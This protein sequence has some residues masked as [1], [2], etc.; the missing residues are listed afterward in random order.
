MGV[1]HD[2]THPSG[3]RFRP[4]INTDHEWLY[5]L[6]E[7]AHRELVER[8]YGPWEEDQQWDFFRP[9]VNNHD[10]F[11]VSVKDE[12]VGAGYLGERDND[13]W[14]ELECRFFA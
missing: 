5:Q 10:V 7:Q 6:H 4:A 3:S 13:V 2:R 12:P 14:L 11:V 9:L 1:A 8:A